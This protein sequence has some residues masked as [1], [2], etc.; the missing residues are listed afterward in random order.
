MRK[1][2]SERC[3]LFFFFLMK[4]E[5]R[6]NPC[7]LDHF[8]RWCSS[9]WW[10]PHILCAVHAVVIS[11]K[12]PLYHC[13]GWLFSQLEHDGCANG[14]LNASHSFFLLSTFFYFLFS[15]T[16]QHNIKSKQTKN[17]RHTLHVPKVQSKG[18]ERGRKKATTKQVVPLYNH[19]CQKNKKWKNRDKVIIIICNPLCLST[20]VRFTS[21]LHH[22][23]PRS[24]KTSNQL[25]EDTHV[26][27]KQSV[28]SEEDKTMS[29]C[30]H[31]SMTTGHS[32]NTKCQSQF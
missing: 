13:V 20:H 1:V 32:Q 16:S 22:R 11:G 17:N 9:T 31:R 30:V 2:V 26:S 10:A 19:T 3:K 21:V 29:T 7:A 6:V 14:F 28:R 5:Y 12:N 8:R 23:P 27:A 15:H 25:Q 4:G 18:R 24:R